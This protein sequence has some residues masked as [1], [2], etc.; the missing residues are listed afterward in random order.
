MSHDVSVRLIISANVTEGPSPS[1]SSSRLEEATT[2]SFL[3][4]QIIGSLTCAPAGHKKMFA[5]SPDIIFFYMVPNALPKRRRRA[6]YYGILCIWASKRPYTV[7]G[8]LA[9]A[10]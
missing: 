6:A 8:E 10:V 2:E 5:F 4:N 3:F 9:H 1:S 7:P